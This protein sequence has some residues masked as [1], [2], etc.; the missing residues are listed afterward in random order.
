M[1]RA[2]GELRGRDRGMTMTRHGLSS[3]LMP[4]WRGTLRV[5]AA[6]LAFIAL[7]VVV[8]WSSTIP[9]FT[10][11]GTTPWS[12]ATGLALAWL[13]RRGLAGSVSLF[14]AVLLASII[15][16]LPP[17]A[18]GELIGTTVIN[19]GGYALATFVLTHVLRFERGLD[20]LSDV[21]TLFII[22]GLS[23]TVV[24]AL[25]VGTFVWSGQVEA[26]EFPAAALR[27]WVG[28][29]IGIAI[30]TP[31][32]LRALRWNDWTVL[33]RRPDLLAELVLWSAALGAMLWII[34][35]IETTNEF[36]FF[37]LLFLPTV[38]IAVRHGIDG[39]CLA[40]V[41]IQAGIILWSHGRGF[42]PSAVTEFQILLLALTVTGLLTGAVVS[43]RERAERATRESERRLRESQ[44]ELE[45]ASRLSALGEMA[46]SLAHELN[47][48]MTA[49]RAY[50]RTAQRLLS[51]GEAKNA[52]T[53]PGHPAAVEA[54]GN[55]VTQIDLA[56]NIVR[57]LREQVRGRGFSP[58]PVRI[59][60]IVEESLALLR[61]QVR[62][63][64]I[65]IMVHRHVGLPPVMAER[66]R[67]QQ[68]LLN[69]L[70]NAI[71]AVRSVPAARRR[72][73]VAA[74]IGEDGNQVEVAVR[75]NG[76]GV[77]P[78][79]A[80]RLFTA[81]V[82]DKPEGLGLGLSICRGIIQAHGGKLWLESSTPQGADFRFT[83]PTAR[84]TLRA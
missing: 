23:A 5:A 32:V 60:Q 24:A 3:R 45:I 69:L 49:S 21:I 1:A 83:L 35:G 29:I 16:R 77:Q 28:D 34:F 62:L 13:I 59:E 38:A 65:H 58:E 19:A 42:G 67:V 56:A 2:A 18:P 39:A 54:I 81:F 12:P 57:T 53:S 11:S 51:G 27:Q 36:K 33:A 68:V 74:R 71:D 22:A 55:A 84:A 50:I 44:D 8:D 48:P 70:R 7:Y 26:E 4:E 40:A 78:E 10:A 17:E 30:V 47:Q 25:H 43:E 73:E 15:V 20:R 37:Y 6:E 61:S 80:E 41:A 75:D 52:S 76:P 31:I 9:S 64:G 82:T 72:I 66:V 46:S 63:A 79:I 14:V